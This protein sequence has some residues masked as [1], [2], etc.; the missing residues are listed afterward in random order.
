MM[1]GGVAHRRIGVAPAPG[2]DRGAID[3]QVAPADEVQAPRELHDD[4][5]QHLARRRTGLRPP[6]ALLRGAGHAWPTLSVGRQPASERQGRPGYQ[7]V[8]Q[9]LIR[10]PPQRTHET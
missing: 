4:H 3:D 9:I 10:Q 1:V 2:E 6:A 7:P 8:T 5:Q